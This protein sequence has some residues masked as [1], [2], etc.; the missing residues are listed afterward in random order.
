MLAPTKGDVW[1]TNAFG[2][3]MKYCSMAWDM[4]DFRW[5]MEE[6]IAN[7]DHIKNIVSKEEIEARAKRRAKRFQEIAVWSNET[8]T[9]VMSVAAYDW[10]P[11]SQAFPLQAV[12]KWG[13]TDY[14][15]STIAYMLAYAVMNG[16]KF[17]DLY[18]CNAEHAEEWAYQRDCLT[19]WIMYAKAKGK[20]VTVNGTKLRPLRARDGILYG[21]GTPQA[22]VPGSWYTQQMRAGGKEY[23]VTM[24]RE[25]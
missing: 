18:G 12:I 2:I 6:N 22:E 14:F 17:I 3:Q 8:K 5:T 1:V 21:Y 11:Y 20:K 10:M 15:T 7:Y 25:E 23:T 19:G 24:F 13:G 4:H 9:P 16:Y